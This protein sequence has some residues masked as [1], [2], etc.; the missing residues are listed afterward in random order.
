M[1]V[2]EVREEFAV[3]KNFLQINTSRPYW[4]HDVVLGNKD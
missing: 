1:N 4:T 2:I 3:S